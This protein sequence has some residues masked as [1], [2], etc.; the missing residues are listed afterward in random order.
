MGPFSEQ[1]RCRYPLSP[2]PSPLTTGPLDLLDP[3]V[4][5][6]L[7]VVLALAAMDKALLLVA[8]VLSKRLD[9]ILALRRPAFRRFGRFT[10]HDET[11]DPS[12]NVFTR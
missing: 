2:C 11:N 12:H 10:A 8:W 3:P 7:L 5:A 9:T 6:V 1:L 4:L